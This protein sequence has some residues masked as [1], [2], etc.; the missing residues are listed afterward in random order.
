MSW[1][2]KVWQVTYFFPCICNLADGLRCSLK[3]LELLRWHDE[4]V[5]IVAAG[6]LTAVCTVAEGLW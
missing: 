3:H 2:R 6:N 5:G 1:G 4:V